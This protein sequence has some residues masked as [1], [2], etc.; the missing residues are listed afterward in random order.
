MALFAGDLPIHMKQ[1]TQHEKGD[2][3]IHV[4]KSF[5]LGNGVF[6]N[7]FTI[8]EDTTNNPH[9]FTIPAGSD[10]A[11]F[12]LVEY[13]GE[14]KGT[15]KGAINWRKESSFPESFIEFR[16]KMENNPQ[17]K[18]DIEEKGISLPYMLQF[19]KKL[20][21]N[22][23]DQINCIAE[24]KKLHELA[25]R[26]A[27]KLHQIRIDVNDHYGSTTLGTPFPPNEMDLRFAETPSRFVKVSY[28]IERCG[29]SIIKFVSENPDK[30]DA[31]SQKIIEFVDSYVDTYIELNTDTKPENFCTEIVDGKIKSIRMLD[32]DSK[33]C[34]KRNS[35]NP[36]EIEEFKRHAK[37]FMKYA[38]IA[39]SIRWGEKIDGTRIPIDFGNL[40]VTQEDVDAML[41]FFY[42]PEYMIHEYNPIIILFNYIP[43]NFLRN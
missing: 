8:V 27:P 10:V 4:K 3:P 34:L 37:V 18:Y 29:D 14:E 19:N 17:F 39:H 28:L 1:S 7:A 13:K 36:A 23:K 9:N 2:L 31:V 26:F 33:Y 43:L 6:K 5:P 15:H 21:E 30:K 11:N 41:T 35:R 20:Y 38:F 24:L 25:P 16:T 32:N 22:H 42:R 12:C 40:G